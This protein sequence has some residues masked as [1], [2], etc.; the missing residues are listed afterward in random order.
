MEREAGQR[1]FNGLL[2]ETAG[3]FVIA[4]PEM[5]IGGKKGSG[6]TFIFTQSRE[7]EILI[8][9]EWLQQQT[10]M[11]IECLMVP[12]D[13]ANGPKTSI[14]ARVTNEEGKMI[15]HNFVF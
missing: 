9:R 8:D 14:Y 4:M 13:S 10:D 5:E 6:N 2:Q 7:P 1:M 12:E 11:L 3:N 15:P